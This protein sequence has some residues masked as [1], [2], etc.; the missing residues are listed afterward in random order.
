MHEEGRPKW[1]GW[2]AAVLAWAALV[3]LATFVADADTAGYRLGR[4][5]GTVLVTFLPALLLRWIYTRIHGEGV[6]TPWLFV[7][8]ALIAV[9]S[10]AGAA[11]SA[12]DDQEAEQ[13]PDVDLASAIGDAPRGYRYEKTTPAD[14]RRWRR[15]LSAPGLNGVFVRK[16]TSPIGVAGT[17]V[18]IGSYTDFSVAEARRGMEEGSGSQATSTTLGGEEI[19]S[20]AF[21]AG[22]HQLTRVDRRTMVMVL[23]R[24]GFPRWRLARSILAD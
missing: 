3:L 22:G 15:Q 18:V 6:W 2:A 9:I 7:I 12:T 14:L 21:P 11:R 19:L 23:V 24:P 8:A 10:V 4:F 17:V 1:L 20:V 16:I 13:P 5:I